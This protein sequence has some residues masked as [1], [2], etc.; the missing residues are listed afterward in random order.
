M[1]IANKVFFLHDPKFYKQNFELI[2]SILLNNDYSPDFIF[3][4]QLTILSQ[5]TKSYKKY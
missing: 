5:K 2:I 4:V 1:I 3:N